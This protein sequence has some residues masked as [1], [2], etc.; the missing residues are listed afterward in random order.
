MPVTLYGKS[1]YSGDFK[2][3]TSG[4]TN[5]SG[6]YTFTQI[7]LHN[8]VYKVETASGTAAV[9]AK[10]YIGV[11]DVV[12]IAASAPTVTVGGTVTVSGTVTPDHSGHVV[13][14]QQ[15]NTDGSWSDIQSSYLKVGSQYSFTYTPGEPGTVALRVLITGGPINVGGVSTPVTITV[16]GL[17]PISQLPPGS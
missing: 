17:A 8:M 12:T 6:N 4:T 15:Q 1:A 16:A 11:Q 3:L 13:Y 9:T 5:S 2:A 14:L 7:P 10:V